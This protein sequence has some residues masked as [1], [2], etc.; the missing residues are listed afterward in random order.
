MTVS[1]QSVAELQDVVRA[2]DTVAVRAGGTKSDPRRAA[3]ARVTVDLRRLTGVGEYSPDECVLTAAA[4]TPISE[5]SL[6]LARHG[7]YLPFDPPLASSGATIGGT[8]A[9]GVSGS[10]R[11]RYG[12]V[13]DFVIGARLV[14]GNGVLIRSG[15]KVVK[16][17]AGF[18]L[19]HGI[20]G[21]GAR[22]GVVTELTLK[23]FP[24]PEA[25]GTV[26]VKVS[27]LS[28]ILDLLRA[29]R[30]GRFDL[31]CLDFEAAG[32]VWIRI[33]GRRETLTERLA[34]LQAA[35]DCESEV[36]ADDR[37]RQL[38]DDAREFSWAPHGCSIVKVPLSPSVLRSAH[39]W[40]TGARF[41]C[42]GSLAWVPCSSVSALSAELASAGLRGLV[43]CGPDAGAIVGAFQ[44]NAFE[45]RVRSVLDPGNRFGAA[46]DSRS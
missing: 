6:I 16:N 35:M 26:Q 30:A 33:A 28:A 22:F 45:E 43:V 38:W 37:D 46:P 7:Q 4:A 29:V 25:R 21:S 18:L 20:V 14:D 39:N 32:T 31:E 27:G 11:Y 36:L 40:Q 15:G 44:P 3:P 41:I 9:A 2:H 8:V 34:A 5:I 24:E 12:G 10:G 42:G 23:V 17:A 1:P 19:H 13:R